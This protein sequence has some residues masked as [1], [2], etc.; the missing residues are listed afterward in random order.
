M[1]WGDP[2]APIDI[3]QDNTHKSA[4][5][6]LFT[7]VY[8][9]ISPVINGI[10]VP[11]EKREEVQQKLTEVATNVGTHLLTAAADK[12]IAMTQNMRPEFAQ[13]PDQ[14][15]PSK[16]DPSDSSDKSTK[17]SK[18]DRSDSSDSFDRLDKSESFF[19]PDENYGMMLSDDMT[20]ST[21]YRQSFI[22]KEKRA[23]KLVSAKESMTIAKAS[24]I[25]ST[26]TELKNVVSEKGAVFSDIVSEDDSSSNSEN[27]ILIESTTDL[28]LQ[29]LKSKS[30]KVAKNVFHRSPNKP[31]IDVDVHTQAYT[32]R[33][34]IPI[35]FD[36]VRNTKNVSKAKPNDTTTF[37][38]FTETKRQVYDKMRRTDVS[39]NEKFKTMS[40]VVQYIGKKNIKVIALG[41]TQNGKSSTIKYV[42]NIEKIVTGNNMKSDTSKITEYDY[43]QNGITVTI[44]DVPGFHDTEGRAHVFY[45]MI[46]KYIKD[47]NQSDTT[48]IDVI[49]WISK[50]DEVITTY[51]QEMI[52]KLTRDLGS[53]FWKKTMIVLTHSNSIVPPDFYETMAVEQLYGA[54]KDNDAAIELLS[55]KLYTHDK[56]SMWKDTF[57][58]YNSDINVL[59]VENNKRMNGTLRGKTGTLKDGTPIIETFYASLFTM[60][61][62]KAPAMFVFLSGDVT[63]GTNTDIQKCVSDGD[64]TESEVDVAYSVSPNNP[65]RLYPVLDID[66]D[67]D[68]PPLFNDNESKPHP[69]ISPKKSRRTPFKST[70]LCLVLTEHQAAL[71]NVSPQVVD[72]AVGVDS[73]TNKK[74]GF[75]EWW[76]KYFCTIF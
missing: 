40:E 69:P 74:S 37:N 76:N 32:H 68:T 20:N 58:S 5:D 7:S 25:G 15:Q 71:N 2:A 18:S 54:D 59:L 23:K 24:R 55:W 34:S 14:S 67:F 57:K 26:Q 1:F 70:D 61:M 45:Q 12:F 51:T 50:I 11:Q 60:N 19:F 10:Q 53:D 35:N 9:G 33:E 28:K 47:C 31:N 48:K 8:D 3:H 27:D 52:T 38:Y 21:G 4:V 44:V 42:F 64:L 65:S 56:I 43:V 62:L 72:H 16:S 6:M 13:G 30:N 29:E 17:L 22:E 75:V 66:T 49:L 41:N 73:S 46:L 39:F 63:N 36:R